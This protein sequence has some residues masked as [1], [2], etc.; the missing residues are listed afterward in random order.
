MHKID[1]KQIEWEKFLNYLSW[2][3]IGQNLRGNI[4][5]SKQIEWSSEDIV[6]EILPNPTRLTE[7]KAS[8]FRAFT[9]QNPVNSTRF[10]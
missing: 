5:D 2:L 9:V 1:S 10:A 4:S 7:S 3:L 6:V 8:G